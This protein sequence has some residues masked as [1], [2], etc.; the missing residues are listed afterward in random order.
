M[1]A[2][3]LAKKAAI[4]GAVAAASVMV[5]P[6]LASADDIVTPTAT[7]VSLSVNDR[8]ATLKYTT[9]EFANCTTAVHTPENVEA[10][11]EFTEHNPVWFA[12]TFIYGHPNLDA[13]PVWKSSYVFSENSS[14]M[15]DVIEG[16]ADGNYVAGIYCVSDGPT[17]AGYNQTHNLQEI[18]FTLPQAPVN[19]GGGFGSIQFPAFGS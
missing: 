18:P 3:G 7:D 14:K 2:M 6:G 19:S 5:L 15:T 11:R 9:P 4:V 8:T 13:D 17:P 10:I 1:R 16:L 12:T